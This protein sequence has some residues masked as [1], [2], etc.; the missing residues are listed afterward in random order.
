MTD[1]AALT[2]RFAAVPGIRM[3]LPLVEG[4]T[5]ASGQAGAGTGA[6]VRGI[7]AEDLTKLK[8]VSDNI[9]SGRPRRIRFG[10]EGVAHRHR[11]WRSSSA[12]AGRRHHHAD[13]TGR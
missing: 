3:A 9:K 5:L 1:Y 7:R 6:L 10:V 2:D 8:T 11:A 12:S 4:Q 13:F